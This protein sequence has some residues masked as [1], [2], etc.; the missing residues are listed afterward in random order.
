LDRFGLPDNDEYIVGY[1]LDG[2]G[3]KVHRLG[4][5]QAIT[6]EDKQ[7]SGCGRIQIGWGEDRFLVVDPVRPLLLG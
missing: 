1:S 5:D 6:I 7:L 3:G 4:I 2:D